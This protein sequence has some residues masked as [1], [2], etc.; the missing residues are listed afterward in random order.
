MIFKFT[1]W[2]VKNILMLLKLNNMQ[3]NVKK[4]IN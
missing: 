4:A 1:A 3:K 2:I